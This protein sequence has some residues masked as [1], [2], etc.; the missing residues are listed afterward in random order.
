M[1][2]SFFESTAQVPYRACATGRLWEQLVHAVIR[3]GR[4][5]AETAT[6]FGVSWSTVRAAL[7]EATALL[8]PD[9]DKL[10][11]RMLGIDEHR[12]R[13]VRFFKDNVTNKWQRIEPWMT[14]IVD[15]DT[16]QIL[17]VVD[18]RDHTGVGAWLLKRP[19]Q[20]RL[21]VQA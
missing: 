13:S 7:S 10:R 6:A 9:V 5:V 2:G 14:T 12:F 4:A 15:L 8:L 17:G 18:G 16:G 11:S 1:S 3:S 21:G 19:L 20:W